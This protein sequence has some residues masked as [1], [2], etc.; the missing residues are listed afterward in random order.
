MPDDDLLLTPEELQAEHE[1]GFDGRPA[2]IQRLREEIKAYTD[3]VPPRGV[4]GVMPWYR[5]KKG[6]LTRRLNELVEDGEEDGE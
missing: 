1:N 2:R 4:A 3:L 6:V 5:E